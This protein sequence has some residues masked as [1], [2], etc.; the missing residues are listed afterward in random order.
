MPPA[1]IHWSYL[2]STRTPSK[3]RTVSDLTTFD[4]E[5]LNAHARIDLEI[6]VK[7][8]RFIR[9]MAETEPFKSGIVREV[10]PGVDQTSDE[11]LRGELPMSSCFC[12]RLNVVC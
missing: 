12:I 6:L 7:G 10:D 4:L 8:F 5:V 9:R 11:Q 2:K 1:P 3:I